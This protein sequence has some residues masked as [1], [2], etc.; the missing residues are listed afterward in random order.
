MSHVTKRFK[1]QA[2]R[3]TALFQ[4]RKTGEYSREHQQTEW[5]TTVTLT[6]EQSQGVTPAGTLDLVLNSAEAKLFNDAPDNAEFEITVSP[7]KA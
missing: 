2:T 6:Q 4:E 7:V 1:L 3:R 5:G